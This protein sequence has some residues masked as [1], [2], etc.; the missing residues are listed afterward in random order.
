MPNLC[1]GT[2]ES[3]AAVSRRYPA[4]PSPDPRAETERVV[5][6]AAG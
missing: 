3:I 1:W 2:T 4:R 6:R 5:N